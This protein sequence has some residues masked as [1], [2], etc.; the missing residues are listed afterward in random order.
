MQ[1]EIEISNPWLVKFEKEQ[2]IIAVVWIGGRAMRRHKFVLFM[3]KV[4]W[5]EFIE[6]F[7]APIKFR[8]SVDSKKKCVT[9]SLQWEVGEKRLWKLIFTFFAT[10]FVGIFVFGIRWLWFAQ[11]FQ[12]FPLGSNTSTSYTFGIE[13]NGMRKKSEMK[14]LRMRFLGVNLMEA[15]WRLIRFSWKCI[16]SS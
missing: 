15:C 10:V 1:I 14:Y 9:R 6:W 4:Y 5:Q 2:K 8:P 12:L 3:G 11:V 7:F 13:V 16:R